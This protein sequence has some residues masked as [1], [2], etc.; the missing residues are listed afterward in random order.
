[1]VFRWK[2]GACV[3]MRFSKLC[4]IGFINEGSGNYASSAGAV[5]DIFH[6]WRN[7]FLRNQSP[8]STKTL[9]F[10]KHLLRRGRISFLLWQSLNNFGLNLFYTCFYLSN[11]RK[12][13]E[14]KKLGKSEKRG[15]LFCSEVTSKN[16]ILYSFCFCFLFRIFI[17][18]FI[19]RF[20]LVR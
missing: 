8:H 3:V 16:R 18:L 7:V 17:Y 13:K 15:K 9:S 12:F 20:I 10:E 5:T 4:L 11:S 14:K 19:F 2:F 1:M 6:P